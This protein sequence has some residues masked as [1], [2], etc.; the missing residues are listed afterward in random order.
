VSIYTAAT[1]ELVECSKRNSDIENFLTV[2]LS[3]PPPTRFSEVMTPVS[4]TLSAPFQ[5]NAQSDVTAC[6][7]IYAYLIQPVQRIPRYRC[8]GTLHLRQKRHGVRNE[9][10]V[11]RAHTHRML[12]ADLLKHTPPS[13]KDWRSLEQATSLVGTIATSVNTKAAEAERTQ[14]VISEL[15]STSSEPDLHNSNNNVMV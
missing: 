2:L 15:A 4:L 10:C 14:K 11:S 1:T 9:T 3:E 7:S 5:S 8:E 6:Q 13:H 12:L